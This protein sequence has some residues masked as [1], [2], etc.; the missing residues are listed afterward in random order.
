VPKN[1]GKY[2]SKETVKDVAPDQ[3]LQ[4]LSARV[5][6][7]VRPHFAKIAVVLSGVVLVIVAFTIY[8]CQ[9]QQRDE[10]AT[11]AFG[12]VMDTI[13]AEVTD[14]TDKPPDTPPNPDA[15]PTFKSIEE[16]NKAVLAEIEKMES[17][18]GKAGVA[19]GT[20]IVKAGVLYD[21]GRHDDAIATYRRV[22]EKKL[23]PEETYVAREG[24]GYALEAKGLEAAKK[25][26]AAAK[27]SFSE[28]LEEFEALAP[29]DKAPHRDLALYHQARLKA[30]LG[31]RAGA[32][33]LYKQIL[34][35]H[36]TSSISSEAENR[37][38]ILEEQG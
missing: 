36:R 10:N 37:L 16:R 13:R 9:M 24:L 19:K 31:D 29:D 7:Q 1:K 25:D 21:L 8:S 14:G 30:L 23:G 38:A 2:K 34:E 15:P 28:A 20:L 32:I 17:E 22:L 5:V 6:E 3:Q 12:K 11:V 26:A 4:S 35:K 27:A 33:A 18:Y